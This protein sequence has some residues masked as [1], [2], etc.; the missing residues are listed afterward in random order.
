MIK[1]C[2]LWH[3]ATKNHIGG[4]CT[5]QVHQSLCADHSHFAASALSTYRCCCRMH[6]RKLQAVPRNRT[7]RVQHPEPGGAGKHEMAQYLVTWHL[8]ARWTIN[9][10]LSPTV[11]AAVRSIPEN[12]WVRKNRQTSAA[13]ILIR[14][15]TPLIIDESACVDSTGVELDPKDARTYGRYFGVVLADT[16]AL[17]DQIFRLRYQVY[18]VEHEFENPQDHLAGYET[19]TYDCHSVH[20]ALVHL[21]SG[22]VCGCV[23]LILPRRGAS[24]PITQFVS[25]DAAANFGT[26]HVAEVSRYAVSKAFRRRT[27]E[28]D[29]PDVH[30]GELG[31]SEPR[32]MMPHITLGLM[33]AVAAL[34]AN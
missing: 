11:A 19:D 25:E 26:A 15:V 7:P 32:R 10:A 21:A 27:G 5:V 6:E 16:P 13:S 23:R 14:F 12:I 17:L 2:S 9:E 3:N 28:V 22:N 18:C 31:L 8:A 24:L 1:C 20:A 34:S 33:L 29:Y 30:F 4:E